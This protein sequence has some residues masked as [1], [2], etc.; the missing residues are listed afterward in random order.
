MINLRAVYILLITCSLI[1]PALAESDPPVRFVTLKDFKPFAWCD[2]GIPKGIDVEI[3]KALFN[4]T[5]YQFTIEC[6]PWKRAIASIRSGKADALFS[7]YRTL[8]REAF[9]LYLDDPTHLSVFSVFVRK[10]EEFT[11]NKLEDLYG[12]HIGITAG[13]SINPEFDA[14]RKNRKLTV[15][16]LSSTE[17]GINM[18]LKGR[19]DAYV[20]GKHVVLYTA[21]SMGVSKLIQGLAKPVHPPKP[22]YLMFSKLAQT[23]NKPELIQILN[24]KLHLM[25]KNGQIDKIIAN[26]T[27]TVEPV[28]SQNK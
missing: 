25:W 15:H 17:S 18:L 26:F 11:F 16:E 5:P 12:K 7:A 1:V 6:V 8:E 28:A 24:K 22:A 21:R 2:N 20:N 9:A 27:T 10:G 3:V 13:Y 23:A 4:Q 19:I 14:A